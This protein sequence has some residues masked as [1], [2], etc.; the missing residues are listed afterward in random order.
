MRDEFREGDWVR[1]RSCAVPLRVIGIG[2][3]IA[4]QFSNGDMQAFEPCELEKVAIGK[5]RAR[6]VGGCTSAKQLV[7]VTF[8]GLIY[9]VMLAWLIA[10]GGR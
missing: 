6:K 8:I 5:V 10:G 2:T 4:V 9:L 7:L 3:T 1:H